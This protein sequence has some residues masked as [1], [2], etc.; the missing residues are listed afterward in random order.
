MNMLP[1]A[2]RSVLVTRPALQN[3]RLCSLLRA[4][5]ATPVTLPLIEIVPN[6]AALAQLPAQ[7]ATADW[8]IFVS[9]SAVDIGW[10]AIA[11]SHAQL[12]CVGRP[13]AVRLEQHTR[14]PVIYPATGNDS[15]A[16]LHTLQTRIQPGQQIL[17]IRGS[18]GREELADGLRQYGAQVSFADIYQRR[19]INADWAAFDAAMASGSLTAAC[20]TSS[21]I[22]DLLF[23]QAGS[24]R[25]ATLQSLHYCVPHERI[26]TRLAEYGA[27]D[28][29][30]I[31]DGDQAMVTAL[32]QRL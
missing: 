21:Q 32:S 13:S 30:I 14:R 8:L 19:E 26:A 1:L 2:G 7:A 12:A 18:D 31:R 9:P 28:I 17:I 22:A 5:G 23:A 11:L 15:S 20:V 25:R 6:P 24:H 3:E 27:R 4:A 16:L 29:M 10:P